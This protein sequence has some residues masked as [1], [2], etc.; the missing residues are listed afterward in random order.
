M[1]VPLRGNQSSAKFTEEEVETLAIREHKRWKAQKEAGGWKY[2]LKTDKAKK[3]HEDLVT[4]EELPE[5]EK[6]KDRVLIR[7][8]PRILAKAGY[9]MVKK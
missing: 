8:I 9:M 7:G 3:L 5:K 1:I 6:E 4:W 2:A